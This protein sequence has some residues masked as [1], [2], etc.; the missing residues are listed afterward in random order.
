MTV[1]NGDDGAG[2]RAAVWLADQLRRLDAE[3]PAGRQEA[4][5]I[6]AR[7]T[8]HLVRAGSLGER[9]TATLFDVQAERFGLDATRVLAAFERGKT[10]L[11]PAF[12][13]LPPER[14]TGDAA[15]DAPLGLKDPE[16]W[17]EPVDTADVLA[18]VRATIVR[19]VVFPNDHA[20]DAVALWA[21]HTWVLD[22]ADYSPRLHVTGPTKRCG[23]S[24]LLEAVGG[25]VRRPLDAVNATVAVVFR[26]LEAARPTLLL[27][28]VD[29]IPRERMDELR[30]ILN[31]GQRRGGK[32]L[33]CVG[34]THEP[35]AF[36]VFGAV[37]LSGIGDLPDTVADRSVRIEMVRKLKREKVERLR[38]A[39]YEAE[40][41]PLRRRLARWALDNEAVLNEAEPTLPEELDDRAQD[42]WEIL[43]AVAD[44][45]GGEWP[46][47]ARAAA[48]SLSAARDAAMA[49]GEAAG[50]R[51]LRDLRAVF[52]ARGVDR[53][54]TA[55]MVHDLRALDEAPW[56][57]WGSRRKIPGLTSRD[58]GGLLGPFGVGSST[59]RLPDGRR[60][61]GYERGDLADPWAR[62]LGSGDDHKPIPPRSIRDAVTTP[63]NGPLGSIPIRDRH[64]LVTDAKVPQTASNSL[65]HGVTARGGGTGPLATDAA[66][67]DPWKADPRDPADAAG[68]EAA[69]AERN[70]ELDGRPSPRWRKSPVACSNCNGRTYEP[71]GRCWACSTAE[72]TS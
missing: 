66:P 32:V 54:A 14:S 11:S 36:D 64:P 44:L 39:T 45:A 68:I 62:Y 20:A 41:A 35:K 61:K 28:E 67:L 15:R 51:L 58:V 53:L 16:P 30:G 57:S 52:D 27:D 65:C 23:K 56:E 40:V 38:V 17:H 18:E 43:L 22:V 25:L 12:A 6:V 63:S 72:V 70:G 21:A 26:A 3:A 8:G 34:D 47:R 31:A 69:R 24:R 5:E 46:E 29:A 19:Y 48:L 71:S 49:E 2:Q 55:E 60:L 13:P 42:G 7:E 10:E 33:R 4:L 1:R 9:A 37:A 50:L 59:L